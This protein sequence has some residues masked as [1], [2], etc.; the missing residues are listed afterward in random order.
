M[1]EA[2]DYVRVNGIN[3]IND[4]GSYRGEKSPSGC[5]RNKV[6]DKWHYKNNAMVEQD[7]MD[8]ETMKR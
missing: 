4:Y 7:G 3:L 1:Y 6:K 8:N 2:Y 5:D